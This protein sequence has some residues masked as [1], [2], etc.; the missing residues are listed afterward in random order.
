MCFIPRYSNLAF[1]LLGRL[2]ELKAGVPYETI[3]REALLTPLGMA[4]TK[5]FL[6]PAEWENSVA[7]G[8]NAS[9]QFAERNT[10]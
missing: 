2:L 3:V 10:P 8:R 6:T 7:P 1:G 4:D 5:I 9:G